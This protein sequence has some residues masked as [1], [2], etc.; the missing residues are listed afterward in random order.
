MSDTLFLSSDEA[1]GSSFDAIVEVKGVLQP[2]KRQKSSYTPK[3]GERTPNDQVVI[4]LEDAEI[5]E[6][7]PGTPA[8][9]LTEGAFKTWMSYAPPGHDKPSDKGFFTRGF[10]MSA[11]GIVAKQLGLVDTVESWRQLKKDKRD[12]FIKSNPKI[13]TAVVDMFN[14]PVVLRKQEVL[15][16]KKKDNKTGDLADITQENFVFAEG[17]GAGSPEEL[18]KYV[19]SKLIGKSPEQM[20]RTLAL[21]ARISK[22]AKYMDAARDGSLVDLLKLKLD[23]SGLIQEAKSE[24]TKAG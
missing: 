8:P 7:K 12:E 2:L 16:Y 24:G 9:E 15:L 4:V 19:I 17:S 23:D 14:T 18:E 10:V 3:E 11:E 22:Q 6:M 5:T 1:S 20:Y 13:K 21:D